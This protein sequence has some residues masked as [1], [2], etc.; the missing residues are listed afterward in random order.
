LRLA[1]LAIPRGSSSDEGNY[2]HLL[3]VWLEY[4]A[5]QELLGELRARQVMEFWAADHYT[6]IYQKILDATFDN[7]IAELIQA[8]KERHQHITVIDA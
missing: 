6:W 4:S 5:D 2:E 3:V 1:Q 8:N 7:G